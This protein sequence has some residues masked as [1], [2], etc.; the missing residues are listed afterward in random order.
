VLAD[1]E[2]GESFIDEER[3]TFKTYTLLLSINPGRWWR[4]RVR[5]LHPT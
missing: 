5:A 3:V 2:M 1:R 4:V